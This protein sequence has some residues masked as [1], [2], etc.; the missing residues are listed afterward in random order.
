MASD[1]IAT[2]DS[3]LRRVSR[4]TRRTFAGALVL[5]GA[6]SALAARELP[7]RTSPPVGHVA[8]SHGG[9]SL[10]PPSEPGTAPG[11][12]APSGQGT[13][14]APL[15]PPVSAPV[16]GSGGGPIVSGGS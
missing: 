10:L 14:S 1:P 7:G 9:S 5:A 8:R 12:E 2:R 6:L 4:I 15:Q 3:G 13:G 16:A 11:I